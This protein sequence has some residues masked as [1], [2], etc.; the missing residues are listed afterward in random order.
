METIVTLYKNICYNNKNFISAAFIISNGKEIYSISSGGMTIKENSYSSKGS[1]GIYIS[2][3]LKD[4]IKEEMSYYDVREIAV[5][6][7]ALAITHDG[8]SGGN[9]RL[10]DLKNTGVASEEILLNSEVRRLVE[11]H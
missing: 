7:L 5:K 9:M 6:A 10:V 4:Q 11:S 8:S 3:F 1:G 2:G